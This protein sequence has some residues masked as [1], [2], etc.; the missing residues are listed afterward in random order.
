MKQYVID[1]LRP[2]DY[3]KVKAYLDEHFGNSGVAGLYWI[4]LEPELLGSIQAEHSECQPHYFAIELL[5]SRIAC[6]LLVRTRNRIH[7]ACICYADT[8]QRSWIMDCLDAILA[9]LG[10]SI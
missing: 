9:R 7:C 5:E 1:E 10:I 2:E 4:P 8:R 6:E 3:E